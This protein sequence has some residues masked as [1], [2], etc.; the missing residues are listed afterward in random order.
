[1]KG[2]QREDTITKRSSLNLSF[3]VGLI[4]LISLVNGASNIAAGDGLVLVRTV[5]SIYEL[6]K[7]ICSQEFISTCYRAD[8]F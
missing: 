6:K 1:M 2:T 5:Q 7:C 8:A 4:I 3:L